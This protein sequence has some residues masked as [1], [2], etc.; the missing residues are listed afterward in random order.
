MSHSNFLLPFGL[1][2]MVAF[3]GCATHK[4]TNSATTTPEAKAAQ[5]KAGSKA[6]E[7]TTPPDWQTER[8]LNSPPLH[9][10]ELRGKVVVVRWWTAGCPYCKTTAPALRG[11]YERY[12]SQGLV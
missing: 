9:V 7:G 4:E 12:N 5:A 3:W 2:L 10:P 8:W 1:R 11:L 6:L